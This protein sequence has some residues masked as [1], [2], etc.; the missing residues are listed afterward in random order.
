MLSG[1]CIKASDLFPP[2]ILLKQIVAYDTG[3]A[4]LTADGS[5]YTWGDE[6]YSACL[7][8]DATENATE[9]GLV[10]DLVDLPTGPIIKLAAG[11]YVLAALT[12][13]QDLYIWGHGGRAAAAGLSGLKVTDVPTPVVVEDHDIVDV[14]VGEGHLIA[15]A[16]TGE[17]YV[18]GSNSNGQLGLGVDAKGVDA[19]TRVT[20]GG[21]EGKQ[22]VAVAAGPKNSFLVIRKANSQ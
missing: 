10:T 6:R 14:A 21:L 8:R 18:I 2:S 15:L 22:I 1:T 19:W 9:P 7:G 17:V 11:G 12:E 16:A 13:G 4:A 20:I 3:F 5:V